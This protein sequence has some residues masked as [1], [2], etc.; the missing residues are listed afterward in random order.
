MPAQDSQIQKTKESMRNKGAPVN[1]AWEQFKMLPT[2][3]DQKGK[4][5]GGSRPS[6]EER[7]K[8]S[9]LRGPGGPLSLEE[10]RTCETPL[11]MQGPDRAPGDRW[12]RENSWTPSQCFSVSAYTQ[13]KMTEASRLLRLQEDE[14]PETRIRSH[15]RQTPHSWDKI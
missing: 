9:P 8:D 7:W 15:P 3:D 11:K 6:S 10:R 13:V 5:Q 1:K 4:I 2:W 14:G 12:Q